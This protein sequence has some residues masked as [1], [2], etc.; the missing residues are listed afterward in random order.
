[1]LCSQ[2]LVIT[3]NYTNLYIHMNQE[4]YAQILDTYVN[5]YYFLFIY[6]FL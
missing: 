4:F 5:I 3:D 6:I 1:M 2:L